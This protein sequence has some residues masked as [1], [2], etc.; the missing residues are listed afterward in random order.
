MLNIVRQQYSGWTMASL[1]HSQ[2]RK[3]LKES[4]PCGWCGGPGDVVPVMKIL[5]WQQ[6]KPIGMP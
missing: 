2:E 5:L 4:P 3:I 1:Y 6:L